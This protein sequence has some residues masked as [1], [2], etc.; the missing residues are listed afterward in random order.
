MSWNTEVEDSV[1]LRQSLWVDLQREESW[2]WEGKVICRIGGN[3]FNYILDVI[4]ERK[5]SG[6]SILGCIIKEESLTLYQLFGE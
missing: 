2:V 3:N 5:R 1:V 4:Y 6:M